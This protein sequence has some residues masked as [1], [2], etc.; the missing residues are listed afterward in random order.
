MKIT[1]GQDSPT[2]VDD[3]GTSRVIPFSA[4]EVGE[5]P[6]D[7]RDVDFRGDEPPTMAEKR[8]KLAA[9][10]TQVYRPQAAAVE[11]LFS[12]GQVPLEERALNTTV[13]AS[14]GALVENTTD[15]AEIRAA[16]DVAAPLLAAT[17][18][19]S[20]ETGSECKMG[21]D[22]DSATDSAPVDQNAGSATNVDIVYSAVAWGVCP[23]LRSGMIRWPNGGLQTP[24]VRSSVN[25]TLGRRLARAKE[26]AAITAML[27][28]ADVSETTASSSA[29]TLDEA[30]TL[31]GTLAPAHLAVGSFVMNSATYLKL[32]GLKASTGGSFMVESQLDSA[33]F[34]LLLG[35]RVY[36]SKY[37]PAI[38]GGAKTI[39]FGDVSK[40]FRR[41]VINTLVLRAYP[42]RYA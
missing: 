42:E 41:E 23:N 27:A 38:A 21:L 9:I 18:L 16:E 29:I 7:P 33:G 19:F 4:L 35:R 6:V 32:L 31:M 3:D 26:S 14:G 28:G 2:M 24:R 17:T 1:Y 36:V 15:G 12:F 34:P 10:G 22:D 40:I 39:G 37:M 5:S 13:D 30:L 11:S 20:T 8:A 25:A